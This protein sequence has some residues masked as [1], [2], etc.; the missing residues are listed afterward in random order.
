MPAGVLESSRAVVTTTLLHDTWITG[1]TVYGEPESSTYPHQKMNNEALIHSVANHVCHLATGPRFVAG[2]WNVSTHSLPVF[3][4]L[5]AAGFLD[6][7]DIAN[8]RWGQ[9]IMP[10]CKHV[11]RKDFCYVSRELQQLLCAC[12]CFT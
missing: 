7:Q 11:T 6:L 12:T 2:D 3:D 8:Q 9:D 5:E 10:T 1:A 4:Q